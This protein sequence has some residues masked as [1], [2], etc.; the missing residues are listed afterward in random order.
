M[1]AV[2]DL[3][4]NSFI[5]LVY[6]RGKILL[7]KVY[8]VGLKSIKDDEQAFCV[9][10]QSVEKI[11][12]EINGIETYAFGTAVFRQRP[13]LFH[14]LLKHFEIKGKILSEKEEAYLTYLCIDPKRSMN[15]TVFDLGGGSLEVVKKDWF[16]SL[17]TGTHVLN[18]IFDLSLPEA[19][20]FNKTVDYV[21]KQLPGFENPVGIGGSFVAIAALKVQKWDLKSLDGFILTPE[22]IYKIS[23]KLRKMNLQ[24]IVDMK[25]IPPGREK[26]I[27]AGCAVAT[28]IATKGNIKVS[29]KGFRYTLA[30]MIEEGKWPA[31]GVPGEI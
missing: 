29:T 6:D 18:S 13:E 16:V 11:Q 7:E 23:E 3:G 31:S 5:A 4:S 26:T 14:R 1:I 22:D 8:E 17:E 27:I 10:K 9:A 28:A 19:K 24:Q 2:L 25:I 15:V 21:L 30:R 20:D 12:S